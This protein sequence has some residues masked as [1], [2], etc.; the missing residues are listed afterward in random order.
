MRHVALQAREKTLITTT[1]SAVNSNP[2]PAP[3]WI[4]RPGILLLALAMTSCSLTGYRPADQWQYSGHWQAEFVTPLVD[5]RLLGVGLLGDEVG[6]K[7]EKRDFNKLHR[8]YRS[9]LSETRAR[10]ERSMRQHLLSVGWVHT[11]HPA[12]T[13]N[14]YLKYTY[15]LFNPTSIGFSPVQFFANIWSP[16]PGAAIIAAFP[17]VGGRYR[18]QV[19]LYDC[20]GNQAGQLQVNASGPEAEDEFARMLARKIHRLN[21]Q[22]PDSCRPEAEHFLGHLG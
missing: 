3:H 5:D 19:Q 20:L 1:Q 9:Q 17:R 10:M 2:T 22:L 13:P 6:G 16:I 15:T 7:D 12:E 21:P 18:V 8:S 4:R 11:R 14:W